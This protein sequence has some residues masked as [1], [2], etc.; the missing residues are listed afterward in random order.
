MC[1]F[2]ACCVLDQLT[3]TIG[4]IFF[5]SL[6]KM[7]LLQFSRQQQEQT[8]PVFYE[9][10]SSLK[11]FKNTMNKSY[12]IL[13]FCLLTLF[14]HVHVLSGDFMLNICSHS[15]ETG[16]VT[17]FIQFFVVPSASFDKGVPRFPV[18]SSLPAT[19]PRI[20]P[21]GPNGG[22]HDGG[23]AGKNKRVERRN[24]TSQL[25]QPQGSLAARLQ[26]TQSHLQ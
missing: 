13:T 18:L 5:F 12:L 8:P 23:W 2:V 26:C 1:G 20:P 22:R 6:L 15:D 21:M 19:S 24:W 17:G 14:L 10:S 16:S 4:Q 3:R 25:P 11:R 9:F 7:L